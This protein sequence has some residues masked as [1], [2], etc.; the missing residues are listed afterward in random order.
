M[1]KLFTSVLNRRLE[2]FLESNQII[3]PGF[4]KT[5][6]TVDNMFVLHLLADILK[7]KNQKLCCAFIDFSKAFDKVWRIGLWQKMFKSGINGK[8][9]NVVKNI[10]NN[11]K[12]CIVSNSST[13]NY[14]P[15]QTG[16]RQGEQL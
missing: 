4:R 16:V 8:F 11:I 2:T 1:G 9:L 10:Y 5:F 7:I 15:C 12:S 3:T 6:S 13:S 14:F